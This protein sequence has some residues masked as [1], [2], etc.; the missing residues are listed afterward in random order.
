MIRRDDPA[1]SGSGLAERAAV[2]HDE[3]FRPVQGN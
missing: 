3:P 2:L 1:A